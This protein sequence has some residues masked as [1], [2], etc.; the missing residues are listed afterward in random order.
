MTSIHA[1]LDRVKK[2][3]AKTVESLKKEL[4]HIEDQRQR[5]TA[6]LDEAE[7]RIRQT[8]LQLG[9]GT[10]GKTASKRAV[11]KPTKGK[12]IRRTPEQLK[13]EA[14][15]IIELVRSKG[16]EAATGL[17]IRAQHAKIGPDIKGFVHKYSG[18]KLK[19]TGV[20]RSMRYFVN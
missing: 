7:S 4:R 11:V 14:Q 2:V 9:Q 16:A 5:L 10:N 20:G 19:S 15:A 3:T 6:D 13:Q 8:L 1:L 18:R 12:R 17:E